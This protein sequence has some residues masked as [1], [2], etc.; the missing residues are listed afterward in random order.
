MKNL[1]RCTPTVILLLLFFGLA[2]ALLAQADP[3]E[4]IARLNFLQGAVSYLPAGGGEADW[5]T[6]TLNR[7]M[8]TGDRLWADSDG[9]SELHIGSNAVRM[10]RSTGISF[11]NLDNTTVQIRLSEGSMILHVR[12]LDPGDRWEVDTPNVAFSVLRPGDYRIDA[13]PDAGQTVAT[14]RQGEG[15]VL[16]GG[17][18]WQVISDQQVILTGAESL[19]YDLRDADAQPLTD[20]DRWA[21]IRDEREDRITSSRYVSRE[22]TG[23]ED[24]DAYGVWTRVPEYGW[25]WR[26]SAV[27]AGWAPYR[28][29]HWIWIAPWGWTWVE[30]EPW[31]FA[32]FHYGRWANYQGGWLWVAGPMVAR[33]VY[34]P[35]LV[36][37]VGGGGFRLSVSLGAGGGIGW[38][39][40]GPR[41]VFLPSY[42][43]SERYVTSVNVTNTVV[44]RA[45]VVNVYN[46][47][48][49]QNLNYVNRAAPNAVTIVAH[50]TFVNA[51]PVAGNLVSVSPRELASAPVSHLSSVVPARSSV[52]GAGSPSALRPPSQSM[53]R[54]VVAKQ[55]P[56]PEPNH[57]AP[58]NRPSAQAPAPA[59]SRQNSAGTRPQNLPAAQPAPLSQTPRP[60]TANPQAQQPAAPAAQTMH[61]LVKPAPAVRPPTPKE[62]EDVNAKQKAWAGAHPR[63]KP[64]DEK[65]DHKNQ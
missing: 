6:A 23:Y 56:P 44:D 15:E 36:A 40:L 19:G 4:R 8:T 22:M 21:R 37:W 63:N 14:V 60:G 53:N 64:K 2:P 48:N 27:S 18:S 5:V 39:P 38:F 59:P 42:Q 3:P 13:S 11:L 17:R 33:P 61:P 9:R 50:D 41:E 12:H 31:G 35:A 29:G 32:P 52:Y 24:L 20:F 1:Q 34:A 54:P 43:V 62:Q 45:T 30:D 47:R 28:Y 16:G 7:P 57:F 55:A 25:C 65:P 58:V 49:V 26:P 10:N 51:R 46:N